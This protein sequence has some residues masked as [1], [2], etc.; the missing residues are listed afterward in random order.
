MSRDGRAVVKCDLCVKR[1]EAG[2]EP[3]CVSACPAGAIAFVDIEE[4][5][6]RKRRVAAEMLQAAQKTDAR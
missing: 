4:Y 5:N 6:R 2:K 3:A 1:T